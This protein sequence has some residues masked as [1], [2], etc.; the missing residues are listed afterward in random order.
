MGA[1]WMVRQSWEH[2]QFTQ[3]KKFLRSRA[4]PQMREAAQ[5]VVDFLVEAPAGTP[6]AGKLVTAPSHSPENTFIKPD[7][8]KAKFTYAATMDLM[9]VRDLL[10]NCLAAAGVLGG[11]KFEP[12]FCEQLRDALNRLAPVQISPR[13][14]RLQEWVEDYAEAEPGHRHMSHLYALHPGSQITSRDTPELLAAARKSLE[15]RLANGGGGTGWS[16]AWLINLFARL[17]DG[18]GAARHFQHLLASCTLP[19]LFDTHPPFQIDGNFGATAGI[20]EMLLQSHAGEIVLLPALPSTWP[21]GSVKGLRARGGFE[22]D[23]AWS[24]GKLTS[25]TVRSLTGQQR[26]ARICHGTRQAALVVFPKRALLL[27]SNLNAVK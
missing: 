23:V 25:A 14:G 9:I 6:V 13:T 24:D 16:R 10:E 18:D 12:E 27:D 26:S 20:A 17:Q 21:S 7:G 4:W 22:V 15:Y 19:N 8:T 2:Y 11:K 5:F 1:A 3:D